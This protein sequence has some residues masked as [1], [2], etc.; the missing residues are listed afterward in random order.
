M[1]AHREG[2]MSSDSGNPK[3]NKAVFRFETPYAKTI[4]QAVLPEDEDMGRSSSKV[5]LCEE[6]DVRAVVLTVEADDI[7]A[8]RAALNTWLRLIQISEE[9]Q[10]A[11]RDE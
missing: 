7:S 2:V 6:G 1:T 3:K 8:L 11:I 5:T 10:E 9:M 4:W